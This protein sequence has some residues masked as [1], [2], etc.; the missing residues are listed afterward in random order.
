[1]GEEEGAVKKGFVD[2]GGVEISHWRGFESL[3]FRLNS[4]NLSFSLDGRAYWHLKLTVLT[5]LLLAWSIPTVHP[6]SCVTSTRF[7]SP[8]QP[9][10]NTTPT[11]QAFPLRLAVS[12]PEVMT[13]V[14]EET[15]QWESI[16]NEVCDEK[17]D[18]IEN[19]T[20]LVDGEYDLRGCGEIS[21][22]QEDGAD[23]IGSNG[24]WEA[25]NGILNDV[26]VDIPDDLWLDV[27]HQPPLL[28]ISSST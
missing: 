28:L 25:I 13:K 19:T 21:D 20:A 2:V 26:T 14:T 9:P 11:L 12:S 17:I 4:G 16:I 8:K 5:L 6:F 10:N 7:S 23:V 18:G 22:V 3:N 27:D 24:I 1:M 15:D